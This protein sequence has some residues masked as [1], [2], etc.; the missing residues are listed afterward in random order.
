M[1]IAGIAGA[2]VIAGNIGPTEPLAWVGDA[3]VKGAHGFTLIKGAILSTANW[4]GLFD[5][6]VRLA[7]TLATASQAVLL[8]S[9]RELTPALPGAVLLTLLTGFALWRAER[10]RQERG[11]S[12]G[13]LHLFA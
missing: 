8:S 6:V 10:G 7:D 5:G 1:G 4:L 9:V 3:A 11:M 2:A 12:Q 13:T